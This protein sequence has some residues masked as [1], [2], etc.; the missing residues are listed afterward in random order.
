MDRFPGFRTRLGPKNLRPPI[1]CP[2]NIA[3]FWAVFFPSFH[4]TVP[5]IGTLSRRPN[6]KGAL[7]ASLDYV[8]TFW[9]LMPNATQPAHSARPT[10]GK[11]LLVATSDLL[12]PFLCRPPSK[13]ASPL[14]LVS[15]WQ[16]GFCTSPPRRPRPLSPDDDCRSLDFP[17]FFSST[18]APPH[19]NKLQGHCHW[20]PSLLD[21]IARI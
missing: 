4:S 21:Y 20:S 6:F 15:C 12:A 2:Q 9:I 1:F 19:I 11:P 14:S 8:Y 3:G 16:F 17:S 13:N 10:F 18:A 5:L 7:G